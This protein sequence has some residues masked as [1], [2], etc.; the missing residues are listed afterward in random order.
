LQR[1]ASKA[2]NCAAIWEATDMA[3]A[4]ITNAAFAA[5]AVTA[6]ALAT[7]TQSPLH[8]QTPQKPI[9]LVY[10]FPAGSAGDTVTRILA[11]GLQLKLNRTVLVENRA[12]AGGITGTRSV[13]AAEAD[14]TTLIVVPSAVVTMIP[15]FNTETGY[16]AEKD[17]T[18]LALLVTQD[19]AL[20]VGPAMP[21]KSVQEMLE[22]VR[23]EPAKG[24]YGT[25]GAGSSLHLIGV[26]LAEVSGIP[27]TPVHYRGAAPSL[28][29]VVAGQL[30][31]MLSPMPDQLEQHKAGNIRIIATA[32]SARSPFLPGVATFKE[33][34]I[35]IVASGWFSAFGPAGLPPAVVAQLSAAMAETVREPANR[36]RLAQIGFV[37][38]GNGPDELKALVS[39]DL[40]F[41]SPIFKAS[42][43]KP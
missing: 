26:K 2:I 15:L 6:L 13:V 23:K 40:A 3:S 25:P 30:P 11:Q 9:K 17:L 28:N 41:W 20:G 27:L 31:M 5:T 16:N 18:P 42:G 34:G 32:G 7:A 10:P 38:Q 1:G 36:D 8:A 19:L 37:A 22:H 4:S 24:T 35:D 12:G 39:K 14:G 33:S 21:V 29:D 43:F